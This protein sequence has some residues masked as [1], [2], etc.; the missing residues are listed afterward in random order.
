MFFKTETSKSCQ[1][2]AIFAY[3][4]VTKATFKKNKYGFWLKCLGEN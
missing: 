2:I 1:E 4:N 3:T